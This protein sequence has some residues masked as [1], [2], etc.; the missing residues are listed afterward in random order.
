RIVCRIPS[1]SCVAV[2]ELLAESVFVVA[3]DGRDRRSLRN[4]DVGIEADFTC[5]A[6]LFGRNSDYPIGCHWTV[7]G[8]ASDV[9]KYLDRFDVVHVD[10]AQ[11]VGSWANTIELIL[12]D[13]K[14]KRVFPNQR[15]PIEHDQG[16]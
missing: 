10:I 5:G 6:G 14:G 16:L 8:G 12:L 9:F 1:D 4:T 3:I 13:I 15:D 7:D 2:V 11:Q